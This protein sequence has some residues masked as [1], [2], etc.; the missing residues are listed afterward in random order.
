LPPETHRVK[1]AWLGAKTSFD[2]AQAAAISKWREH[3]AKELIPTRE[4]LDVT[5]ALLAIDASLQG[6][7]RE[8]IPKRREN[9][10]AKIHLRP[11]AGAGKQHHDAK[12]A[13]E[14]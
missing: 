12:T 2:I 11:P 7:S 3:Q 13:A 1:L 14:N 6:V 8:E 10:A 4:V 5:M 9:T